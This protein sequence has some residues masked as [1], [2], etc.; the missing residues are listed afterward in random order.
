MQ[1]I[2]LENI[3]TDRI[4]KITIITVCFNSVRTIERTIRSVIEQDY[5]D[6]EYI[7]I[8]GGSTDGTIDIIKK[9]Q[10]KIYAWISE[11]DDGIYDAMNKG[12]QRASGEIFAFLNSDDYYAAHVLSSVKEYFKESSADLVSGNMYLCSEEICEKIYFDKGNKE[13]MFFEVIY[14][15]PALFAR[16]KLYIEYGGFDTSYKIAADTDWIMKVCLNGAKVLC[17]DD[18]FTYFS[19]GGISFR[20]RYAGLEEQYYIALKHA[21]LSRYVYLEQEIHDFYSMKLQQIERW[22]RQRNAFEKK[23][24]NIKELFNY[25]M[26]YYIWGIGNRGMEC[27]DILEKLGLTIKGFI[28]SYQDRTEIKGYHVVRP[29]KLDSLDFTSRICI[30]PKEFEEEIIGRLKSMGFEDTQYFIYSD[31]LD[32]ITSLGDAEK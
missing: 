18:Y 22:E 26:E 15:H 29:E 27:L 14:P 4:M 10:N 9:Y 2:Q 7:V 21:R 23:I 17:V 6:L 24:E 28:D 19:D 12:L 20:K 13:K 25:N 1:Q 5:D 31:M 30:T 3:G 32:Q 8:D 11:P 16:R